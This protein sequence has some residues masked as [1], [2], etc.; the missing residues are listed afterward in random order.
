[1]K[2]TMSELEAEY[3][4][5]SP[6]S[7]Q[8][9][10]LACKLTPA[11]V[12][13]NIR[14]FKPYPL[15]AARGEG[16]K[17]SDV[18]GNEY[19]DYVL[20]QGALFLGH[21]HPNVV[22]AVQ[23]QAAK[24]SIYATANELEVKLAHKVAKMIPC[25]EMVRFANSGT[26]ALMH[27]VRVARAYTKRDKIV[28]FEGAYH[29]F[30]DDLYVGVSLPFDKPMSSGIPSSVAGNTLLLEFNKLE[31]VERAVREN[32]VAAIVVEPVMGAGGSGIAAGVEYLKGLREIS[33]DNGIALIF[34]E[35]ITGFRMAPGGAQ[36]Y[37]GVVP[38]L[39]TLGKIL[40]GGYPVGALAG[41]REI[42][43]T[44]DPTKEGV[45][46]WECAQHGGTFCGNPITM[47]A[48]L[49][50]LEEIDRAGGQL[51]N[52]VARLCGKIRKD[53]N[54]L[55]L[56]YRVKARAIGVGPSLGVFFT[57][58]ELKDARGLLSNDEEKRVAHCIWL[59][60]KGIWHPPIKGW[61]VSTAHKDADIQA[62]ID[63][64]EDF[65][66]TTRS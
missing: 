29:G 63:K 38:D 40:G 44:I 31:V 48:G 66:K 22:K 59:I 21:A 50:T 57:D 12:H 65:L 4:R 17:I 35:V 8:L 15:F 47:A 60:T 2:M 49:A 36:Q 64:T 26:E 18:D 11:G 32:Q 43:Q 53:L 28:K 13:S 41:K 61:Y 58:G 39:T 62:L 45:R 9:F 46:R 30:W 42:M 34:D 37:F 19:I 27:A 10:D 24:G 1:M 23:E 51:N 6:R 14:F 3:I 33:T 52:R 56:R 25:A 5:R 54:D 16:S 20:G 7:K 55:F